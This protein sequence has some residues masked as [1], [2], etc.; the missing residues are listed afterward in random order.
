M[1]LPQFK[2][3][4]PKRKDA[5]NPVILG[6]LRIDKE[7][8]DLKKEGK[9]DLAMYNKLH[10]V[11]SQPGRLYGLAKV[12]KDIIPLRPVLSMPGTA[13]HKIADQCT[14]WLSVVDKCQIQS[15]TKTICDSL[16]SVELKEDKEIVSFDVSS[17]YTNVP[18][19]E[20]I[21]HCAN[22]LYSVKYSS[23]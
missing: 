8:K 5:N 3:Y 20:A 13:Y 10:T 6:H 21:E 18:V 17:L 15:D 1:S 22:L 7:L 9:I 4:V 16:S 23:C 12:H 19:K 11:G 2:K 14:E